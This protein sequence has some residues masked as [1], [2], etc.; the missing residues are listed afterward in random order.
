M[1]RRLDPELREKARYLRS[2]MT[3]AEWKLWNRLKNRQLGVKFRRQHPIGPYIVDFAAPSIRLVIEVD[4]PT[5]HHVVPERLREEELAQRGWHLV[6]F[7][8]EDIYSDLEGV[9]AAL[10]R[11]VAQRAG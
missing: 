3:N 11:S 6:R 5:H 2:N 10:R 1:P 8:N 4:G 9:V 7:R